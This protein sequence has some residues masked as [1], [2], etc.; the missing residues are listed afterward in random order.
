M[1]FKTFKQISNGAIVS[2]PEHYQDH[3]VFGY[4][5]VPYDPETDES[6][7]DK[8]VFENHELPVEQRGRHY[9]DDGTT[10]DGDNDVK[11]TE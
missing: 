2:Y 11:E 3:P 8:V 7:V 1:A 5:L 4:D 9:A 10:I 6:E